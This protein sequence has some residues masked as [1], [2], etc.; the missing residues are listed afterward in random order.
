MYFFL[1]SALGCPIPLAF[2]SKR[3]DGKITKDFFNPL[4]LAF[5]RHFFD[6][7]VGW[8]GSV[9]VGVGNPSLGS[10]H[11]TTTPSRH[12]AGQPATEG[13]TWA[14]VGAKAERGQRLWS[15][16]S[17]PN[18][19][20]L[21]WP[22]PRL[23]VCTWPVTGLSP[24]PRCSGFLFSFPR[25]PTLEVNQP[26]QRVLQPGQPEPRWRRRGVS[27]L[28]ATES[29]PAATERGTLLA[30]KVKASVGPASPIRKP[31]RVT[32]RHLGDNVQ[33]HHS[34]PPQNI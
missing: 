15:Q 24:P 12:R 28:L 13:K 3:K 21:L 4:S 1:L 26:R 25:E 32:G 9:E 5:K 6:R 11:S 31:L 20:S 18:L 7:G 22:L 27:E 29:P 14:A 17:L 19:V 30:A 16:G 8:R 33:P 23:T 10:L 2:C 34:S